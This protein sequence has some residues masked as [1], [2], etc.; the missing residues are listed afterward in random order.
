MR[1][2]VLSISFVALFAAMT[3]LSAQTPNAE[4]QQLLTLAKELALKQTEIADNEAKIESKVTELAETLRVARIF[5][6][7][8]GGKPKPP[9]T[10]K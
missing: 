1:A 6:S 4:D 2:I 9:R 5:V 3:P 8:A 10:S 7:R